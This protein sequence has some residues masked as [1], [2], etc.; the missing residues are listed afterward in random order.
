MD[1]KDT[2]KRNKHYRCIEYDHHQT[3][4]ICLIACG[5]ERPDPGASYGPEIRDCYHL[6]VILSGSGTLYAGGKKW[7]PHFG[8]MFLLKDNEVVQYIAD[9]TTPWEYCWVTYSGSEALRLSEEI[10]FTHGIYCLDSKIAAQ[11]FF[12]LVRRMHENLEMNYINDLRRRGILF[13]FLA[14][15]MESTGIRKMKYERHY[16]YSMDVYIKKALEFIHNN[17]DTIRI[18][19][20]VEYVGFSRSYFT[21]CFHR[22]TGVSPQ[23]YLLQYRMKQGCRL[24]ETT[25]MKIQD[26]AE[27]IGYDSGLN[28]SRT[29]RQIYGISPK[30]YRKQKANAL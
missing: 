2:A 16:E 24:L 14:L 23:E 1:T 25:D 19:D 4:D 18:S 6:H 15:A 12:A 30:G 20:V 8:Q 10:G 28:F 13:E 7:H 21:H 26:I 3:G 11:D 27:K 29:F 22:H 17:Y 5:M 9:Q